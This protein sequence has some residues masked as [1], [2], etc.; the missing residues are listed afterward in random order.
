[1]DAGRRR[2]AGERA[3][4]KNVSGVCRARNNAMR[5]LN[6]SN[7]TSAAIKGTMLGLLY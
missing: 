6:T 1:M 5:K 7:K 2:L 3:I 4:R